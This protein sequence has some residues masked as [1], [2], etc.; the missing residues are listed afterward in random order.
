MHHLKS[1]HK[2]AAGSLQRDYRIRP[3]VIARARAPVVIGARTSS[4]D[5][6]QI[7]RWIG[8]EGRPCVGRTGSHL[9]LF[10]PGNWVPYPAQRAGTRIVSAYH[11][12]RHVHCA[13]IADR[14]TDDYEV[15][16]N[17]WR[18]RHLVIAAKLRTVHD[19]ATQIH[20]PACA[21]IPARCAGLAVESYQSGIDRAF[22]DT[23]FAGCAIGGFRILPGCYAA[24]TD[25]RIVERAVHFRIVGPSCGSV[26]G[27]ESDYLVEGC[28]EIQQILHQDW[29]WFKGGFLVE[30]GFGF[31]RAGMIG[32]CDPKLDDIFARDLLERRIAGTSSIGPVHTPI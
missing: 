23:K 3:L 27:V 29:G 18:R 16:H 12:A 32:P 17:S 30:I 28:A 11:S 2:G 22:E 5:E 13:V 4:W 24:R 1:P 20:R 21:K 14:R 10:R 15:P 26:R 6:D 8:G 31:Q 7:L 9:L 25:L 19:S